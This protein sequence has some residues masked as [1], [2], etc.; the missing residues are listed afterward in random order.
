MDKLVYLCTKKTNKQN[1]KMNTINN[2]DIIPMEWVRT[3]ID[4]SASLRKMSVGDVR[5]AELTVSQQNM[6][7]K[8]SRGLRDCCGMAFSMKNIA[9]GLFIISRTK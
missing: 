4:W 7:Y 3:K 5:S 6:M 9:G 2:T 8:A 1:Y